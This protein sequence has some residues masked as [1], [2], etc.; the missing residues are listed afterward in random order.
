MINPSAKRVTEIL[1][2]AP[3]DSK[4]QKLALLIA[5]ALSIATIFETAASA[6]PSKEVKA[7]SSAET[8]ASSTKASS[9]SAKTSSSSAKSAKSASFDVWHLSQK[10]MI[11]GDCEV[12]IC[13]KGLKVTFASNK[14]ANLAKPP[15]WDLLVFNPKAKVYCRTPLK[16]WRGRKLGNSLIRLGPPLEKTETIAGLSAKVYSGQ[17]IESGR[18]SQ[19]KIFTCEELKLP[20]QISVI[21][22]GN[23]AIPQIKGIPLRVQLKADERKGGR[24]GETTINTYVAKQETLPASFFDMPSG[25]RLV[26]KPEDVMTGGISDIIEEM[27]K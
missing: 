27:V 10:N 23:A 7:R 17:T 6:A 14:W 13:P 2:T 1:V 25:Y 18:R 5:V 8:S 22:C 12:Y 3:S 19:T 15:D 24:S 16:D 21:L 4:K 20:N 26:T 9:S 11:F